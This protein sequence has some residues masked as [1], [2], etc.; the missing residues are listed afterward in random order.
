MT[1]DLLDYLREFNAKERFFL[2]GHVIGNKKFSLCCT[3]REDVRRVLQLQIPDEHFCAMDYH[4]DWLYASLQL[5]ADGGK[6]Q[7]Y[8]NAEGMVKGQQEDIDLLIGY[9]DGDAHHLIIVEAKGVTGWTNKQMNSKADRL[10]NIFGEN[11][12]KWPNVFPHFLMASPNEPRHLDIDNWPDWM[13]SQRQV[14][15]FKLTIPSG[16]KRVSR[17]DGQG[18]LNA[19]GGHWKVGNR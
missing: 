8:S 4:F 5:N 19:N 6:E 11:G 7:V 10:K 15:M 9:R 1:L 12:Q 17:C 16:L 3:F 13:V 18:T 2:I 14:S